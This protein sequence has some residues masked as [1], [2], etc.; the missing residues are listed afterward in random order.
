MIPCPLTVQI[1]S[2]AAQRLGGLLS[3]RRISSHGHVAIVV[4]PGLGEEIVRILTPVLENADVHVVEG[5]TLRAAL[6]LTDRLRTGS[7]D[8]VVGIGEAE[9]STSRSTRPA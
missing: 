4:G 2:G 7:H 1:G 9:H 6:D 8:A 5:G 3:D